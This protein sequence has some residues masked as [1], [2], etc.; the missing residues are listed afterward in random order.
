MFVKADISKTNENYITYKDQVF[1]DNH[2][3]SHLSIGILYP[4]L[5]NI[6]LNIYIPYPLNFPLLKYEIKN[7]HKTIFIIFNFSLKLLSLSFE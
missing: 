6:F 3:P 7:Y 5:I 2:M 1:Q 4:K